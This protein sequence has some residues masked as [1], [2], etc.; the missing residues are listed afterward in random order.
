MGIIY[1]LRE[2]EV[3]ILEPR[4]VAGN[5]S[6]EDLYETYYCSIKAL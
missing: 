6:D 1:Q 5:S 2:D 4:F 3:V